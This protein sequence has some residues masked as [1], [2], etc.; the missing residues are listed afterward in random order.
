MGALPR[1]DLPPGPARVFR[2]ALHDLHH[3]AGW[4]SLRTL[5]RQA[6]VSHTTISKVFSAPG[7]PAW[8]IVDVVVEAMGGDS[9]TFHDLW[10]AGS[11][12]GTNDV[13]NVRI[14]GRRPELAVVQRHLEAST[15]LLLVTGEAG[16]G[17]TTLVETAARA[18][19]CD[20]VTGRC[21]PLSAELPLMPVED[22]IRGLLNAY[23]GRW[24]NQ[25]LDEC[26]PF[27]RAALGL[28][29]PELQAG[30]GPRADAYTRQQL[31]SAIVAVLEALGDSR[32]FAVIFE[33][34]QW[35]D[36]SSLDLLDHLVAHTPHLSVVATCRTADPDIPRGTVSWLARW[37][38]PHG[39][40]AVDLAPLDRAATREQLSLV[41]GRQPSDS[42]VDGVYARTR[43]HPLFTEL[44]ATVGAG[45]MPAGLQAL[46][47]DR[48][49]DLEGDTWAV[50]R[51]LGVADR[52][53]PPDILQMAAGLGVE[54]TIVALRD[55][56]ARW[57]LGRDD[58]FET[59]AL[60]HP[61]LAEAVRR[62]LVPGESTE[63]HRRLAR[64]FGSLTGAE[65]AEVARHWRGGGDDRHELPWQVAAAEKAEARF[66]S[67]E[68][69]EHWT[70]VVQLWPAGHDYVVMSLAEV[71]R[72]A[73]DAALD[74]GEITRALELVETA[75]RVEATPG[76][77]AALLRG[78]G[79]VLG[80]T[81]NS[82]RSIEL[83]ERALA[84][85]ADLPPSREL[86]HCL[87]DKAALMMHCGQFALARADIE[88]AVALVDQV[89]DQTERPRVVSWTAWLALTA[90]HLDRACALSREALALSEATGDPVVETQVTKDAAGVFLHAAVPVSEMDAV[91][92]RGLALITRWEMG[93][94]APAFLRYC[95]ALAHVRA[96]DVN[97]AAGLIEPVTEVAPEWATYDLHAARVIIEACQGRTEAAVERIDALDQLGR[98]P[99]S[100]W[101][102]SQLALAE[103]ECWAGMSRRATIRL[104]EAL[105]ILL[106]TD[107][108]IFA[109]PLAAWAAIAQAQDAMDGTSEERQRAARHLRRQRDGAAVD[110]FGPAAVG[111]SALVLRLVWEGEVARLE[112]VGTTAAWARAAHQWDRLNRPHDAAYCRWRAAQVALRHGRGAVATPLLRRAAADAREHVPLHRAIT[113]TTADHVGV[114]SGKG[115]STPVPGRRP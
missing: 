27:V 87:T 52:P 22:L 8:G 91:A 67:R 13:A 73:L 78:A 38:R 35:A 57:L 84:L 28:L 96:G 49:D 106:P 21:L 58:G 19:R 115:R 32:R 37:G 74:F 103:A 92:A 14:A 43:G 59:A 54:R 89:G 50:V 5:A 113:A 16:I 100:T 48:L 75:D 68:A 79:D 33:D 55:L 41:L 109:A 56:A 39:S 7:L 70:R 4:P 45:V 112:G 25:A 36:S 66:A 47:D 99:D 114:P 83:F 63:Q 23:D 94:P 26:A 95:L 29:L 76:E 12:S 107:S 90:G 86:L 104:D 53:L 2:D 15:G 69:L 44:L 3:R 85:H 88:R 71:L 40:L 81:G 65:P 46:F 80:V 51:A 9:P 93:G 101:A 20:V 30:S 72:R 31:F 10:L 17:K 105:A 62:R 77:R 11:A 24:M 34:L 110:P 6:G 82:S 1:P 108:A 60:R 64:A 61:L 97:G 111:V 18:T 42:I 102:E 98:A